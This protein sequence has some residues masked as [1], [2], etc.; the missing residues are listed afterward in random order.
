MSGQW[1][2]MLCDSNAMSNQKSQ[3]VSPSHIQIQQAGRLKHLSEWLNLLN[4]EY[5]KYASHAS[6]WSNRELRVDT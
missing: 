3:L 2:S 6:C 1:Q 5:G 4:K